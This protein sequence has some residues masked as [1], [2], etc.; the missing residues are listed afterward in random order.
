[1][2][3]FYLVL[4]GTIL[5]SVSHFAILS[6]AG[7]WRAHAHEG[8]S[9]A[10]A[11]AE[12]TAVLPALTALFVFLLAAT[13]GMVLLRRASEEKFSYAIT[14]FY[15]VA[16]VVAFVTTSLSAWR[17]I[18]DPLQI[19]HFM[20]GFHSIF[21]LGSVIVLDFLFLISSRSEVLKQHVYSL[22][23]T[24]SKTVW[25]GLAIDFLSVFL[26]AEF[27]APTGK[28]LFTQTV[29]AILI[30]NGTILSGPIA[31]RMMAS[32]AAGGRRVEK[33]WRRAGSVAGA[34]SITSWLTITSLDFFRHLTLN[35]GALLALYLSVFLLALA[36]H[37]VF[38]VWEQKRTPALFGV[39]E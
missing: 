35:Y 4:G 27:F 29:V 9:V 10:P 38:E 31:R 23:P 13:L 1:M 14:P 36:G 18:F 33:R 20:H 22:F 21:T 30:V 8:I 7:A 32:V 15:A 28:F 2:R 24:I 12:I 26:I 17:G 6:I 11:P 16:F 3:L 5:A 39:S 25:A 37:R 19:F 34:L